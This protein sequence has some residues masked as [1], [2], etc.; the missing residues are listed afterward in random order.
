MFGANSVDI[1]RYGAG[2]QQALRMRNLGLLLSELRYR[3]PGT[4]RQL[5]E[6]TGLSAATVS[7][8][9]RILV[10]Q[11]RVMTSSTTSR[12]RRATLVEAIGTE[13]FEGSA[14]DG[15]TVSSSSCPDVRP[16]LWI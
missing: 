12:G 11:D 7:N 14:T 15:L 9:V 5:A 6:R 1:S 10:Q 13:S 16:D 8:L 3:G 4:Q 2:S